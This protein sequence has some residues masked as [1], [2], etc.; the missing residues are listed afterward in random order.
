MLNHS[1]SRG[2]ETMP[3]FTLIQS[4]CLVRNK[5]D[6]VENVCSM[7]KGHWLYRYEVVDKAAGRRMQAS[8]HYE[9]QR[10]VI[11]VPVMSRQDKAEVF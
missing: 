9:Y 7:A 8:I 3:I 4:C 5:G 1:Q 2:P 11:V 10:I 6:E